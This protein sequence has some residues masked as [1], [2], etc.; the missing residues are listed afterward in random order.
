MGKWRCWACRW[1]PH[2]MLCGT[3]R[4]DSL[5]THSFAPVLQQQAQRVRNL[6]GGQ[7]LVCVR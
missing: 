7:E 2:A 3:V 4:C 5:C 6:Y 1:E